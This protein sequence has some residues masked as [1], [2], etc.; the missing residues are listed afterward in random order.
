MTLKGHEDRV[1]CVAWSPD[2]ARIAS[3]SDDKTVRIWDAATGKEMAIAARLSRRGLVG[4]LQPR[5]QARRGRLLVGFR[6]GEDVRSRSRGTPRP[7]TAGA[8]RKRFSDARS[9]DNP[10][11]RSRS[12]ALRG[13]ADR[14]AGAAPARLAS[15]SPIRMKWTTSPAVMPSWSR[16]H[17]RPRPSY[18]PQKGRP[19][20]PCAAVTGGAIAHCA[21]MR[22]PE[23]LRLGYGVFI[24]RGPKAR[25][26]R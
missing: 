17:L 2:G 16:S 19:A 26:Y 8:R 23:Q 25:R 22:A 7:L 6:L 21:A 14:A 18:E 4:G 1:H 5:R 13:P 20:L 12:A 15:S 10:H 24:W 9:S 11:L 3:G